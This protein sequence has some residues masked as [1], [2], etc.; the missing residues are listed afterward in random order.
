MLT[1]NLQISSLGL[2]PAGVLAIE[3]LHQFQNPDAHFRSAGAFP[4]SEII[5]NLSRFAA[6]LEYVVPR[7]AGNYD[8][9]QQARSVIRHILDRVLGGREPVAEAVEEVE[10]EGG[11]GDVGG[12]GPGP[13]FV[14]GDW[15]S[16]DFNAWMDEDSDLVRWLHSF[17]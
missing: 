4:R 15:M 8:V 9:C 12:G 6:D 7:Q 16:W 1:N 13:G 11:K 17:E 3:L 14:A 2:P 5:Q 10:G